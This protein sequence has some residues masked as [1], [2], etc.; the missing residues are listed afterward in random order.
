M[1][2]TT[3]LCVAV[4]ECHC[5]S[6]WGHDF[7]PDYRRLGTIRDTL[8]EAVPVL[9]FTG[10]A[11]AKVQTDVLLNLRLKNNPLVIR[12]SLNRSNLS[13]YVQPKYGLTDV[14]NLLWNIRR[15]QLGQY[16]ARELERLSA[17]GQAVA[18]PATLVY[19]NT[20]KEAEDIAQAIRDSATLPGL[21]TACYHS[22]LSL[23][24]RGQAHT[25]F[26]CDRVQVLVCTV[27]YGMGINKANIRMV[28]KSEG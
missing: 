6:E 15:Q 10:S 11:T 9:A 5:V 12:S 24:E 20:K 13:Y 14:L 19:V 4:D 26:L 23:E 16:K 27:A 17:R 28:R 3:L 18:F 22:D 7:R 8:G 1:S 2:N 25:S 21:S